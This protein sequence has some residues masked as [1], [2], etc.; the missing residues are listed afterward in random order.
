MTVHFNEEERMAMQIAGLPTDI[1]DFF[2]SGDSHLFDLCE[3]LERE[4]LG[5][6]LDETGE[7]NEYGD[8]VRNAMNTIAR[9]ERE[10]YGPL[11]LT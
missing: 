7:L 11:V 2:S 1:D 3:K 9:R 8:A 5:P 4:L 10:L 6:G